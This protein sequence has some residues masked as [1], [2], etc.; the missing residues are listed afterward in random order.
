M[1]GRRVKNNAVSKESIQIGDVLY[2]SKLGMMLIVI[3]LKEKSTDFWGEDIHGRHWLYSIEDCT[4]NPP[5][6]DTIDRS[7]LNWLLNSL[8]RS[9]YVH[10]N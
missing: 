10:N 3:N 7:K 8:E 6:E 2:H 1:A 4:R 5:N 9:S